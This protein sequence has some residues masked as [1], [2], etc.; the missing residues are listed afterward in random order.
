MRFA[1]NDGVA[2]G[3]GTTKRGIVCAGSDRA[4]QAGPISDLVSRPAA[5][6]ATD[7]RDAMGNHRFDLAHRGAQRGHCS[8]MIIFGI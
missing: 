6:R 1:L 8:L 7:A 4:N 3:A 2:P 5:S